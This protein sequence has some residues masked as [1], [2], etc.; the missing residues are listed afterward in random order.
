MRRLGGPG[1]DDTSVGCA[2]QGRVVYFGVA[3]TPGGWVGIYW[4]RDASK[5]EPKENPRRPGHVKRPVARIQPIPGGR[6]WTSSVDDDEVAD[7]E[8]SDGR[9]RK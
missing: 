2:G 5:T 7:P 6:A 4:N 8:S 3:V 9:P 1:T